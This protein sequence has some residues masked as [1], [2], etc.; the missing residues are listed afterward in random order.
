MLLESPILKTFQNIELSEKL[1][2]EYPDYVIKAVDG[3][4]GKQVF[5]TNES[6]DS[7]QKGIAGSDFILQPFV[8]GPGV[9]LRVY[10]IGKEIVGAVKRQA[11]NSFRSEGIFFCLFSGKEHF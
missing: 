8:K 1:L 9:D 11:N 6:F 7:I 3:H 10:V 5:L 2:K 4:G